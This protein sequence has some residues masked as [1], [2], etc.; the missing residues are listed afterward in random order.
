MR[1]SI[2]NV[3]AQC[4]GPKT[5][6]TDILQGHKLMMRSQLDCYDPRLPGTGVFDIKTRACWPI[7]HDRANY[8]VSR[9]LCQRDS[10]EP[11]MQANSV[12]EIWKE[13][14]WAQSYERE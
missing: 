13:Q 5:S 8:M 14:G 3:L 1:L 7:R 11:L 4:P 9:Q 6:S 12:Y 10:A 2:I